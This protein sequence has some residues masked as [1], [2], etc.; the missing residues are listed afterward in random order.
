MFSVS[1][2]R[3]KVNS[4]LTLSLHFFTF[5]SSPSPKKTIASFG[6]FIFKSFYNCF[7][8]N[9]LSEKEEALYEELEVGNH[10]LDEANEKL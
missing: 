9:V 10:I 1:F 8:E 6:L 3:T 5:T 2:S 4:I 7:K